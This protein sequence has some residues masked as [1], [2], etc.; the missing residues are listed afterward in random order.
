MIELPVTF[1]KK[2]FLHKQIKREGEFAIYERQKEGQSKHYEVV[3][4]RS[5]NGYELAG[6]K[7]PPAEMYPSDSQWGVFGWTRPTL[8]KAEEKFKEIYES[9]RSKKDIKSSEE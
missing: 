6:N 7:F 4:I 8:E 1:T 5:H 3:I 2:K 9:R